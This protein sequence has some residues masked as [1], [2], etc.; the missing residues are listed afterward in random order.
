MARL[1]FLGRDFEKGLQ[2]LQASGPLA[3][4]DQSY[5]TPA[6]LLRGLIVQSAGGGNSS[7]EFESARLFLEE[8]IREVPDDSRLYTALAIALA[9]LGRKDEAI[10]KGK[11]GV[12]ILPV[13]K[14]AI[15]GAN[16]EHEL[17]MAYALV[18][19]HELALDRLEHIPPFSSVPTYGDLKLNPVWD[20]LRELPRFKK[21]LA[22]L[23]PKD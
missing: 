3:I 23:E 9:G 15:R 2:L 5:F 4:D 14:E 19:E 1:Y 16:R 6:S 22:S 12:A 10:R 20:P 11:E 18:G 17:A 7:A 8:R 13:T 21:L